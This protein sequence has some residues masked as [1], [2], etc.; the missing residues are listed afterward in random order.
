[1]SHHGH[2]TREEKKEIRKERKKLRKDLK[3]KGIKKREEFEEIARMLGLVYYED[4]PPF[5]LWWWRFLKWLGALGA[6]KYLLLSG[7]VLVLIFPF[8][9]LALQKGNFVVSMTDELIERSMNFTET[10]DGAVNKITLHSDVLKEVNPYSIL[11]LP[12]H[13]NEFEGSHNMDD[14]VAYTFWAVNNGD[15]PIDYDYYIILNNSTNNVYKATWVMFYEEDKMNV[16]ATADES[17]EPEKITNLADMVFYEQAV[18][19][20]KMFVSDGNT[21]SLITKPYEDHNLVTKGTVMGLK[22]GE[23]KKYTVVIWVEME[24]KDCTEDIIGGHAGFHMRF[25]V[26]GDEEDFNKQYSRYIQ[27]Y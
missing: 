18:E 11:D 14:V 1:M 15:A 22:P 27:A 26:H 20:D 25:A 24:D 13:L 9:L 7:L 8:A 17:G 19:P 5:L 4:Y 2:L 16:F 3:L 21:Y 12:D 6:L 10:A 23:R